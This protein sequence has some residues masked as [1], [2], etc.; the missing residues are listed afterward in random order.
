MT[1]VSAEILF[2]SFMQEFT[3]S[4]FGMGRDEDKAVNT[5]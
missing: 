1:D 4:S 2:H 3:M 5:T